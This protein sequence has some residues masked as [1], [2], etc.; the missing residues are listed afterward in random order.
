MNDDKDAQSH[1]LIQCGVT[2]FL[3]GLLTGFVIPAMK[4]P[5]MG[6]SSHLEGVLN[7]LF[8]IAIGFIWPRLELS[9]R[10]LKAGF[11]T[12]L[13]GTGANWLATFLAAIWGAGKAMP[14]AG[15]GGAG[16]IIQETII[17]VLLYS[18]SFLMVLVCVLLLVGLKKQKN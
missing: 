18:L 10:W 8:L 4:N 3:I 7:G 17:N 14:M 13:Y 15:G 11:L 9:S 16:T 12:A 2:L 6:L 5:R 1:K